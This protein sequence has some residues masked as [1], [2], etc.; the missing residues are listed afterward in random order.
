MIGNAKLKGYV[1]QDIL[2]AYLV[3]NEIYNNELNSE[4]LFDIKKTKNAQ[5][6]KFD[7]ISVFEKKKSTFYQIK[8][9][10]ENNKHKLT[11]S[12]FSVKNK[13][14]LALQTLYESWKV[15]KKKK[16]YYR[17]CLAWSLPES[18][19]E[20]LKYI[21]FV[22][23]KTLFPNSKCFKFDITKIWPNSN[24]T[25]K[26][27]SLKA[28]A[29]KE[30]LSKSDFSNFLDELL[31]E[32][33]LPKTS[34]L[35]N[36]E[37]E[38]DSYYLSLIKE[39]GIGQFPN[40]NQ[41]PED[42]A[43][44]LCQFIRAKAAEGNSIK[45]PCKDILTFLNI[46]TDFG[47][48]KESFPVD[49]EILIDTPDRV[50]QIKKLLETKNKILI[51][52][53][54]GSG[55]SW[56]INNIEK[57]IK[58]E[59][60]II[61]HYCYTDLTDSLIKDRITKN[62]F[63][64][65]LLHQ[66]NELHLV[67]LHEH[68]N[69]Y[70][71]NLPKLNK[72]LSSIQQPV[73]I[74]IDG[75]DH[76]YRIFEQKSSEL[77]EDE[78]T[79]IE[80]ISEIDFSNPFIHVILFSQP[81]KK[82]EILTN[83]TRFL[84]PKLDEKYIKQLLPKYGIKNLKIKETYI[85]QILANK[86]NGNPLFISYLL[87][88]F[89]KNN[90]QKS[91][92]W[93]YEIPDYDK[94]L[95]DYYSYLIKSF[96]NA[97]SVSKLLCCIEYSVTEKELEEITGDGDYVKE[98]LDILFPVLRNSHSFGYSIYH[99][100]F[101]RYILEEL[102]NKNICIKDIVLPKLI[103]WLENKGFY[104]NIKSYSFLL[105]YYYENNEYT[106]IEQFINLDFLYTSLSN[107]FPIQTIKKNHDILLQ[108]VKKTQKLDKEIILIQQTQ[109]IAIFDELDENAIGAL[110]LAKKENGNE[111]FVY[112]FLY[113]NET[114][115]FDFS[116]TYKILKY[117]CL[118]GVTDLNWNILDEYRN[119][120]SKS[121]IGCFI[122]ELLNTGK[123]QKINFI[124]NNCLKKEMDAEFW[125]SIFD[126]FEWFYLTI[127]DTIISKCPAI[128]R[129][130]YT[131]FYSK[132]SF[133]DLLSDILSK[134]DFYDKTESIQLFMKFFWV[135]RNT[136]YQE[137]ENEI[138]QIQNK[139]W[140]RNWVIFAIK[141]IKLA[142]S[143][144]NSKEILSIFSLLVQDLDQFKGHPRT[145]DL[146][147]LE[148]L[149][150]KTFY[151]GLKLCKN[152]LQLINDCLDILEK[153]TE[154][155]TSFQ[156][157]PGGPL[158]RSKYVEIKSISMPI[159]YIK[160]YPIENIYKENSYYYL[161]AEQ[162]FFYSYL[163]SKKKQIDISKKYFDE[164]IKS[165]LT[166]RTHKDYCLS[167][168]LDISYEFHKYTKQLSVN[169]F[170]KLEHLS[171]L[172]QYHTDR[173]DVDNIPDDWFNI[174]TQL[175]PDDSVKY[176]VYQILNSEMVYGY[177][178]YAFK[179]LLENDYLTKNPTLWFLLWLSLPLLNTNDIILKGFR[180]R[181]KIAKKLLSF[182]DEWM[183][184]RIDINLSNKI[185]S[186]EVMQYFATTYNMTLIN[187][188]GDDKKY[189]DHQEEKKTLRF[190][191]TSFENAMHYFDELSYNQ[192]I[193][194]ENIQKYILTL[195]DFTQKKTIILEI[196]K[197]LSYR[198]LDTIPISFYPKSDEYIFWNIA[199]FVYTNNG[200]FEVLT[201]FSY[202][203][204]AYLE[205]KEKTLIYLQEILA[206][207]IIDH[208][209]SYKLTS[210]LLTA[211]IKL[212][213]NQ[214]EISNLF[215]IVNKAI[216]NKFPDLNYNIFQETEYSDLNGYSYDELLVTLLISRLKTFT[217]EKNRNIILGIKY[218]AETSPELI[219]KAYCYIFRN[220]HLLLPSQRTVL[221][222]ILY[223][224]VH[225]GIISD[226]FRNIIKINYPSGFF[227]EDYFIRKIC[228]IESKL[229][230]CMPKRLVYPS[231]DKDD[232]LLEFLNDKYKS[233]IQKYGTIQGFYNEYQ[234]FRHEYS[235]KYRKYSMQLE[236]ICAPI[237]NY[238]DITYQI[239]Y[240]RLY[241]QMDSSEKCNSLDEKE[242]KFLI[243]Q[244]IQ[245]IT[246]LSSRPKFLPV[247]ESMDNYPKK[248][249]TYSDGN[250][251]II[252]A[253]EE[254][255]ITIGDYEK[256]KDVGRLF[257]VSDQRFDQPLSIKMNYEELDKQNTFLLS[258]FLVNQ[259]NLKYN[260][261]IFS[262]YKYFR[263]NELVARSITWK[264]KYLG[265][266]EDG[267]E[268]P[269]FEGSALLV[270][271]ELLDEIKEIY[272]D[273]LVILQK[274]DKE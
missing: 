247:V 124:I 167:D 118:H 181:D 100:S 183:R 272:Q 188:K 180:N 61:K 112:N 17:I 16:N 129:A 233:I 191:A 269:T 66:L 255:F 190:S 224:I 207:F 215:D 84:L 15:L 236:K 132:E 199:L 12:D 2:S 3:M 133:H 164:G 136:S 42:C 134:D 91:L 143:N 58:D 263:N 115:A 78:I 145:C 209:H 154:T 146:Y 243:N 174:F 122:V 120:S 85:S 24:I 237:V 196:V 218:I 173:D 262:G 226:D 39:I 95:R 184:N 116:K 127:D 246:S 147:I 259:L 234:K 5:S 32:I 69:K 210:N 87:K 193:D 254:Q 67:N 125:L 13:Y 43:Y 55:K 267:Y 83:F 90:T 273:K 221:L 9:S 68:P 22:D 63:L 101:K 270:K 179:I 157:C 139:F 265:T 168:L 26:W 230:P 148:N 194:Y 51:E 142:Q 238:Q 175:Y 10:D 178:E 6:D 59:F 73:L 93:I 72:V 53:A 103:S 30:N 117:L 60:K 211:L 104:F 65:S 244:S 159:K 161:C 216:S 258:G 37:G 169:D 75:L 44:K 225:S 36:F 4:F 257:L 137:I 172:M 231:H 11:K 126:S 235:Q 251:I 158:T 97:L 88:E 151:F 46:K 140:F 111:D 25:T 186:D 70:S 52:G 45:I 41:K 192:T 245:N 217:G 201:N 23:E 156:N 49:T 81:I 266:I 264:E 214:K 202:I 162:F 80:T 253:Y 204:L 213:I 105:Q 34:L 239:V 138:N 33:N 203:Q 166:V 248:I 47:G 94:D 113:P 98:Q 62:V 89:K 260:E 102:E 82:L 149:I 165:L 227:A 155:Q 206:T 40:N 77:C 250:W 171:Y 195:N 163:F 187:H 185:Y 152:N 106:K 54:P 1:Y 110:L 261:D 205:N 182:F 241:E 222:Q 200:G 177:Y 144:Y 114:L 109:T 228:K 160:E 92:N 240:Q 57:E 274:V 27:K 48:I 99:E 96:T 232:K 131:F 38:L 212:N 252:G 18:D 271:K 150:H 229:L 35:E 121:D 71:S 7:D 50:F 135:V 256:K 56:L 153:L 141:I 220:Q 268:I 64:G 208:S 119:Q 130:Y 21:S 176:L 170:Y 249:Q 29:K 242:I 123:Y 107:L 223:E 86:S 19:D 14:D 219:V 189:T 197:K 128:I 20:I 8:Y 108:A 31:I 79:I 198:H 74:I 28:Y 76:I